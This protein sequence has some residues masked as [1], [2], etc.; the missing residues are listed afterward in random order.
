MQP[1]TKQKPPEGYTKEGILEIEA[2][3]EPSIEELIESLEYALE[4]NDKLRAENE[5]LKQLNKTFNASDRAA[6][7]YKLNQ[8]KANLEYQVKSLHQF[9]NR[10]N[11]TIERDGKILNGISKVLGEK[12]S[13]KFVGLIKRLTNAQKIEA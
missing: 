6:E 4:Q 7:I 13:S 11:K 5:Q 1:N 8:S 12:D 10:K 3:R 2:S 9:I